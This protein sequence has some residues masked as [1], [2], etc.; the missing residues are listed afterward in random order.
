[1]D[2]TKWQERTKQMVESKGFTTDWLTIH[3]L[4]MEEIGE[5][6]KAIRKNKKFHLEKGINSSENLNEEFADVLFYLFDLA[7]HCQ[8]NLDQALKD[9]ML[10]N[11]DRTWHN[12]RN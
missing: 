12:F 10:K 8:I 6:T 7:N 4:L 3:F 9:K 1:M 5:L 11:Q 2:L